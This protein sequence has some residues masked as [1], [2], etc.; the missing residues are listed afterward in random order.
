MYKIIDNVAE[1][2]CELAAVILNARD[3]QFFTEYDNPFEKKQVYHIKQPAGMLGKLV[4]LLEHQIYLAE[5]V[6]NYELKLDAARYYASI[7]RYDKGSKLDV[8]VD[9]GINPET[10]LRKCVTAILYLNSVK[11]GGELEFWAGS[12]CVSNDPKLRFVLTSIKPKAGRLVLFDNDD[13]AWHGIAPCDEF[14]GVITVS[15]MTEDIN[16]FS[17]TRKKAFF[18]PRPNEDWDPVTRDL[19]DKRASESHAALVY[20]V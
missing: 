5:M 15:F 19:R 13:S 18:V 9:A 12:S 6:F 4:A 14:R 17:N 11:E 8:H 3:N 2:E 10:G 1:R 16:L 7:F 20:K